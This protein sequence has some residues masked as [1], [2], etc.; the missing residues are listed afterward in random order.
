[1]FGDDPHWLLDPKDYIR[2][3]RVY[4][5][6]IKLDAQDLILWECDQ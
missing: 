6:P 5:P 4:R 3:Y 2:P 1:M